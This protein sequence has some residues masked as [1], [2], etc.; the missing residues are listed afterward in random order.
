MN[1]CLHFT[2]SKTACHRHDPPLRGEQEASRRMLLP[3]VFSHLIGRV[4]VLCW[5]V[6]VCVC[7]RYARWVCLGRIMGRTGR[8][9]PLGHDGGGR[10]LRYSYHFVCFV[11][12]L[13]YR[14]VVRLLSEVNSRA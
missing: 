12:V 11:F 8:C 2:A 4:V 6:F 10:L 5:T 3:L 13:F 9:F 7:V 14:I 1:V